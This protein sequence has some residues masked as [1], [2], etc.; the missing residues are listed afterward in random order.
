MDD[1]ETK[2]EEYLQD[3]KAG[4]DPLNTE[5][6]NQEDRQ[7]IFRIKRQIVTTFVRRVTID[8]NRELHVEINLNLF[9]LLDNDNPQRTEGKNNTRGNITPTGIYP[10]RRNDSRPAAPCIRF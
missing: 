2:V 1:W 10:G 9:K 5:P 7:E 4:I 8:H 6:E 3:L